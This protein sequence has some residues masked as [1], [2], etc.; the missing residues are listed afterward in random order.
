MLRLTL[1]RPV[2]IFLISCSEPQAQPRTW[3]KGKGISPRGTQNLLLSGP[4]LWPCKLPQRT[5]SISI[6]RCTRVPSSSS[7][8]EN[9][10]LQVSFLCC[11]PSP[12]LILTNFSSKDN[13]PKI[14]PYSTKSKHS[15]GGADSEKDPKHHGPTLP[16][17]N[18]WILNTCLLSAYLYALHRVLPLM[19]HSLEGEEMHSMKWLLII[20]KYN[21][22]ETERDL[23]IFLVS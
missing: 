14:Y 22:N 5:T 11:L 23:M 17:T 21:G 20:I 8:G 2:L 3:G 10:E 15:P 4:E 12:K 1:W 9:L 18:T 19:G 7:A 6:S 16:F 13:T